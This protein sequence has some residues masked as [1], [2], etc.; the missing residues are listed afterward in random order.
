VLADVGKNWRFAD[1]SDGLVDLDGFWVG[2]KDVMSGTSKSS[3]C[4]LSKVIYEN[5]S[6]HVTKVLR[7][8]ASF[9]IR[10]GTTVLKMYR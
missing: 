9:V 1:I 10:A 5:L 3:E 7:R 8:D 6:Y 4:T 2:T